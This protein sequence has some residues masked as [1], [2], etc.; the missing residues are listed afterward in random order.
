[1][2]ELTLV[3]Q[4]LVKDKKLG[5]G[6]QEPL[7]QQVLAKLK[8]YRNEKE[9]PVK[10]VT[11][12]KLKDDIL[13]ELKTQPN[14]QLNEF[15]NKLKTQLLDCFTV[16]S[17]E[18]EKKIKKR[19]YQE[20]DAHNHPVVNWN[21]SDTY[22]K[23]YIEN[24]NQTIV[25]SRNFKILDNE[26]EPIVDWDSFFFNWDATYDEYG[27]Q[28]K[29]I[30]YTGLESYGKPKIDYASFFTWDATY[31]ENGNQITTRKYNGL[32]SNGNLERVGDK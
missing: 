22:D 6:L 14:L 9:I 25:K 16:E 28:I 31:D 27:N 30:K 19:V 15:E 11:D 1:M 18:N 10:E 5:L 4:K 7:V 3:G 23:E 26:T 8:E 32:D 24:Q 2:N 17:T 13:K 20:I 21:S 12:E 29:N